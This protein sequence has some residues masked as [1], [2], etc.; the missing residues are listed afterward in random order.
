MS[1]GVALPLR[2][3]G[4]L[5]LMVAGS[6]AAHAVI[7]ILFKV[8]GEVD[9]PRF[10]ERT[11]VQAMF[12]SLERDTRY[13]VQFK[14]AEI[15]DSSLMALP[16]GPGFSG[17]LWGRGLPAARQVRDWEAEPAFL[18]PAKP[19][20]FPTLLIPT[21]LDKTVLAS[22][23]PG[24]EAIVESPLDP[25]PA[26]QRLT[27]SVFRLEGALADRA[28]TKS[29]TLAQIPSA[30]PLR[31]TTVRVAAG[32]DG[33]VR[34]VSVERSCGSEAVDAQAV[35]W[36]RQIRFEPGA[37]IS[38]DGLTWGLVRFLWATELPGKTP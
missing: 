35:G 30:T 5:W 17:K 23:E 13:A 16:S 7:F 33:A 28:V 1:D 12:P 20:A 22:A 34:Y 36:A 8:T 29:P 32:A 14:V 31:P 21:P 11:Q 37:D 4:V 27:Q 25:R 10:T 6:L 19:G 24:T 26:T 3:R 18:E 2:D 15:M 38:R 9:L